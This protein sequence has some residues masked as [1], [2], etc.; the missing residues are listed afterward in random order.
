MTILFQ[1]CKYFQFGQVLVRFFVILLKVN[2]W[3][4]FID[5]IVWGKIRLTLSQASPCFYVS[6]ENTGRK[7]GIASNWES[8][9]QDCVG[10]GGFTLPF[11]VKG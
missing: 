3:T 8:F 1:A 9:S 2:E 11:V 4:E 10:G 6:F 7:G 5:N